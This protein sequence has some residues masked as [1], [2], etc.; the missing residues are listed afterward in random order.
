MIRQLIEEIIKAIPN[1]MVAALTLA[2]GWGAGNRLTA[3]WDEYKKRRDMDMEAL[4]AF[5]KIYGQFFA[6]LKLW[7]GASPER[8][9]HEEFR[10]GLLERAASVEGELE[11]LLVRLAAEHDLSARDCTL[12]GCFRQAFQCLRESIKND[13]K[14]R[15]LIR[16]P[17]GDQI[18]TLRWTGSEAPPYLAFEAL[19]GH[20]AE[21]LSR[22]SQPRPRPRPDTRAYQSLRRITSNTLELT[23]L[24]ITF[25]ELRLQSP[26]W[27]PT[28]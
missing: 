8:P 18:L 16:Q 27:P 2:L 11:A 10:R 20:V 19:S 3:K 7:N 28:P 23:W 9:D 12:L 15:S 17:G 4:A 24:E 21:L 6:L 5:Y 25:A 26:L 13:T 22:G 14:M 1:F